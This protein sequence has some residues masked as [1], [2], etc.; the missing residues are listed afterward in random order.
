MSLATTDDPSVLLARVPSPRLTVRERVG[1]GEY[2]LL[3]LLLAAAV[4]SAGAL[5]W[6]FLSPHPLSGWG[7]T[8]DRL[9]ALLTFLVATVGAITFRFSLRYL[10]GEPG[11]AKFLRWLFG[12]IGAAYLLMLST[13]LWLLFFAW[14]VVSLGLHQLLLY[15]SDRPEAQRPA[16]KKFLISRLGDVALLSAICLVGG[17][18]GTW[19]VRTFLAASSQDG[20]PYTALVAL[21]IVVAALT[22]S[23]Q[24]PFHSWLPETMEA[25]TPVSALMHAGVINA[26]GA[27][28]LRFAPLLVR[29]PSALF[30]LALIGTATASLGLL[31]M[32][33]QP[34]VKRTLAWSTVSQM[35]FMMAECGMAAF[36][37]AA[38]HIVG[39]GFYKA[40][41][42]L[43]TGDVPARTSSQPL[44][45]RRAMIV[46][47]LGTGVGLAGVAVAARLAGL[48]LMR[49]PAECGLSLIL[50]LSLGQVWVAC[51][52]AVSPGRWQNA[53]AL[54]SAV[55]ASLFLTLLACAV[56]GGANAFLAPV[57]LA[58][59]PGG[60]LAWVSALL[61]VI[62]LMALCVLHP[63]LPALMRTRRGRAFHVHALHGFYFGPVADRLVD[64]LWPVIVERP[65]QRESNHEEDQSCLM[66]Q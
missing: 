23:A 20:G 48:G 35:G 54:V 56:Y 30:V 32:W 66:L 11:Q 40:W 49:S 26:G 25:P 51:F 8:V 64:R 44:S 6:K 28:L 13:N 57:F 60:P 16:R 65:S 10:D 33:A 3:A 22:K 12:T 50:A 52:R 53:R 19:D 62:A 45:P 27:L 39:H 41:T 36:S 17:H 47:A 15:Y 46:S 5:L 38:L 9:S 42:F 21:L 7:M 1:L 18:W 29:V 14:L 43:R 34:S 59:A 2:A 58:P 63:L 37:V 61:P 4:G 24:F 31:V 55:T